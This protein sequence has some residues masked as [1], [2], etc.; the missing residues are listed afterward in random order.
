MTKQEVIE[1]ITLI[2]MS[3][4]T[5]FKDETAVQ[6][7]GEIWYRM[8]K[9]DN[10]KLVLLAVQKHI[11]TNK[12]PPS[13]AE[14]R[15]QMISLQRPD[16]LPPDIAWAMVSDRIYGD[17]DGDHL[18]N[19]EDVFPPLIAKVLETIGWS[20][21]CAMNRGQYA[22]YRNGQDKQV[23][24]ELYKPAYERERER[25]MLPRGLRADVEKA[26][27]ILG[28][29]TR[30]YLDSARESRRKQEDL[31]DSFYGISTG[32]KSGLIGGVETHEDRFHG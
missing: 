5:S 16:I 27:R 7:M 13:I 4:P 9:D 18:Y 6:A 24:M 15:E 21:L 1:L 3:Y 2:V 25:A 11:S 12:W 20:K 22:G 29:E 31:F 8:F 26:E 32:E 23:F 17:G 14:I 30:K 10:P 19:I 28:G